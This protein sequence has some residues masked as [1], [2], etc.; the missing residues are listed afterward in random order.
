MGIETELDGIPAEGIGGLRIGVSPLELAAGGIRRNPIAI[1]RVVFPDERVDHPEEADPKRV[2][3]EAVAYEVTRLLRDNITGGTGTAAYTGCGGQAGKTGTT[4]NYTDAWFAGYQPNLATAVW[5]GYPESNDIEM[6][7][8]HGTTVFGGTFPAQIWNS[9]YVNGEVPCEEVP[10]PESSVSWAPYY[11]KFTQEGGSSSEDSY[12]EEE[13][14]TE[15]EE[16]RRGKDATGGYD[17]D[18]YAP[19]AGQ[20]PTPVPDPAPAPTPTPTPAPGGGGG[21]GTAT[22][23]VGPAG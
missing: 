1:R 23:G 10:T 22:G 21:G 3:P 14:G 16:E 17:P 6:T 20:E 12:S 4:D 18:A 2:L 19:G 11:G 5:V 8:V 13:D 15:S 7:S 9:L